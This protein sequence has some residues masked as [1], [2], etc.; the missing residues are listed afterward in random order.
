[1]FIEFPEIKIPVEGLDRIR[2][3]E[4]VTIRQTYDPQK[5]EDLGAHIRRELETRI[6]DRAGFK[7]KRLCLTVGSRGIP[8]L[9]LMVKTICDV[10]KEWGARPFIVPAMGS[11]G[12]ASAAGQTEMLAGYGVTEDA[13]GVPILSSMEVVQYGTLP[14]GKPL[15][16]DKNAW[17]SDGIIVFN[18]VKP[19]T[20]F[21]GRHESGIAKMIAI[22]LAKHKGASVFHMKGFASFPEIVP[23]AVET[24]LKVA[25]VAFAIGLV[26]NA[27]DEICTIEACPRDKI[28]ETDARLLEIAKEKIANFKFKSCDVLII[29]EIGKNISGNGHD[30]N[31]VGR[32]N[33]GDFP[34]VFSVQRVFIRGLTEETHHNGCGLSGADITTGRCLNGVDWVSTWTNVVTAN[35][36]NGGRIP[37][38]VNTDREALQFAIKTCDNIDSSRPRVVRIK[39]TLCMTEIEVSVP[40]YEEIK[41]LDGIELVKGPHD[42]A[43]DPQGFMTNLEF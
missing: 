37:V 1:M 17:E 12:G 16:C 9:A 41:D 2:F 28:L 10:V 26:Q 40:L 5:I 13:I 6:P 27:Y 25:P 38:Y 19:H 34:E 24:F 22:G 18:K 31:V 23:Q 20:D 21:R 3:P 30:P 14:D 4:M 32:N 15:Y 43:F 42:I 36:L 39:N 29:D 11:H 33:S 8:H 35:R 7:G